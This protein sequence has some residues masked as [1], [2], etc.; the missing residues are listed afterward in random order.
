MREYTAEK[1][2]VLFDAMGVLS[3]SSVAQYRTKTVR[4]GK[5][6]QAEVFPVYT[7]AA[8]V[9]ELSEQMRKVSPE[10]MRRANERNSWKRMHRIVEENFADGDFW[11]TLT[12]E[13]G[14]NVTKEQAQKDIR[15]YIRRVQRAR[16]KEGLAPTK[17]VYVIEWGETTGNIHHHI[18]MQ[19]MDW[20]TAI[21]LWGHGRTKVQ[22]L[23]WD[24]KAGFEGCTKYMCKQPRKTR[25]DGTKYKEKKW[26]ASKGMKEPKGPY[27]DR[28]VSRRKVE[29]VAREMGGD[30]TQARIMFEKAYPGYKLARMELRLNDRAPGAYIWATMY[31]EKEQRHATRRRC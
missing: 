24:D 7:R 3:E 22:K 8:E 21:E 6:L 25:E 29:K 14:E 10:V 1:Y 20:Y 16:E 9:R 18:I 11:A 19:A 17:Y 2:A 13:K 15:N 4:A 26:V 12:Y 5:M 23:S 31:K 28:K 30:E 27:S